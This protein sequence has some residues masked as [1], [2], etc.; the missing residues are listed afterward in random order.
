MSPMELLTPL[1]I[2]ENMKGMSNKKACD[3]VSF[4][5]SPHGMVLSTHEM[6]AD[7]RQSRLVSKTL[8]GV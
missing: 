4:L 2:L 3:D 5:S 7:L 6:E 1:W 8:R